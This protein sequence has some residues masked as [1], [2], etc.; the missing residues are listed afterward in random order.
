M[1]WT[2]SASVTEVSQVKQPF[3]DGCRSLHLREAS[4]LIASRLPISDLSQYYL[5]RYLL[6]YTG[7]RRSD[8][9]KCNEGLECI[10]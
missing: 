4:R 1:T 2:Q 10:G 8:A 3:K 5:L 6:R 7:V 9:M